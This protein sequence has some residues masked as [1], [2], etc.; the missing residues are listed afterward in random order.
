M[1]G[2]VV[3]NEKAGCE[4]VSPSFKDVDGFVNLLNQV[5][6][7]EVTI[8]VF[9]CLEDQPCLPFNVNQAASHR[10]PME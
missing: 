5:L 10:K 8:A 7:G 6:C 2:C 3:K 1:A 9:T 4:S